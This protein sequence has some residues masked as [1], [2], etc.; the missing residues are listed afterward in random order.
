MNSERLLMGRK[1]PVAVH[2]APSALEVKQLLPGWNGK[3][4]V[5]F[6]PAGFFNRIDPLLPFVGPMYGLNMARSRIDLDR[7]DL[8][9]LYGE[10]KG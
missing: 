2:N 8:E 9:Q 7:D 4:S 6:L 10:K 1:P 3:L 5:L